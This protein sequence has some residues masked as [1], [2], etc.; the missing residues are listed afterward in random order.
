MIAMRPSSRRSA[1]TLMELMIVMMIIG[2]LLSFILV[3]AVNASRAAQERATQALIS[4]LDT[5]LSDRLEA[6]MAK[7]VD[8]AFLLQGSSAFSNT[9]AASLAW[10]Y[11]P[12]TGV[13]QTGQS[14][15]S[16]DYQRAGVLARYD[17]IKAEVPDVFV[18]QSSS[19][20]ANYP[21]NF[22]MTPYTVNAEPSVD[23]QAVYPTG[24]GS[25]TLGQAGLGIWGAS[26]TYLSGINKNLGKYTDPTT[27]QQ[28]AGYFPQG[29]NGVDDNGNTLIDELLESGND[30]SITTALTNH[31]HVT[32]RAEALYALLVEGQGPYGSVF[33]REDFT[34]NEV[35]DTDQ[36]GLPEFVDGWGNPIQ[37]YRWPIFYH[38]D[39]QRGLQLFQTGATDAND[40]PVYGL[41]DVNGNVPTPYGRGPLTNLGSYDS[42]EQDPLDQ[43]QELVSPAWWSN[44]QNLQTST[45]FSA[46]SN[47]YTSGG[48]AYF[49][50]YF[51]QLIEPMMGSGG[52]GKSPATTQRYWDRS[53]PGASFASVNGTLVPMVLTPRRAFYTRYLILSAGPDGNPGTP[54]LTDNRFNNGTPMFSDSTLKT[55][56]LSV[57]KYLMYESQAAQATLNRSNDG[58]EM[59][60]IPDLYTNQL[61]SDGQDD[62]TNHNLSSTALPVQ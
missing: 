52:L 61:Q 39:V 22:A 36:D 46:N 42:R 58:F 2:I 5:G 45:Q 26:Y 14:L 50:T 54:Y 20:S 30:P 1:F 12:I 41:A 56:G 28:G 7:R 9:Q 3:A 38:S 33:N 53:T 57:L 31:K 4:K 16:A 15:A 40:N 59:P 55:Q 19:V 21:L 24:T 37:F 27:G 60:Q 51:H 8:P 29:Y 47:T 13:Q 35:K 44:V 10:S 18:I 6:L 49:Q 25:S 62:I 43:N 11:I 34:N 17:Q 32:A 23:F 48:V